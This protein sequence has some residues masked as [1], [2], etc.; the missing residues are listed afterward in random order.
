M[1]E[2]EAT[3]AMIQSEFDKFFEF[4]E[5]SDRR[6]VTSVSCRLFAEH[7]YERAVIAAFSKLYEM[8]E[9]GQ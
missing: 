9:G 2:R 3:H 1:T 5:G 6:M 7:I 8:K 4:P